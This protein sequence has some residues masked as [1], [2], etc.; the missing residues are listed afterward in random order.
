MKLLQSVV[1][2]PPADQGPDE[3]SYVVDL[4]HIAQLNERIDQYLQKRE[5]LPTEILELAQ[6][7]FHLMSCMEIIHDQ[8]RYPFADEFDEQDQEFE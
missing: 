3:D 5:L 8:L 4:R 7:K 1:T 6:A 2:P